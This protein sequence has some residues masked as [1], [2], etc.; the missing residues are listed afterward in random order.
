MSTSSDH[1]RKANPLHPL[2]Q[3]I[4]IPQHQYSDIIFAF[5]ADCAKYLTTEDTYLSN[6][7]TIWQI[8]DGEIE[9]SIAGELRHGYAQHILIFAPQDKIRV[10]SFTN[11]L[12]LA[13]LCIPQLLMNSAMRTETYKEKLLILPFILKQRDGIDM[14]HA[15]LNE[16]TRNEIDYLFGMIIDRVPPAASL[17]SV[18]I[19]I[20]L[21]EALILMVIENLGVP[22]N[23]I[24]PESHMEKM[25][26]DFMVSLQGNYI[27]HQDVAFYAAQACVSVKYFTAVIK[28]LT[29]ATPVEWISRMLTTRAREL[30]WLTDR[31]VNDISDELRFSSPS[32]FIRFFHRRTGF[33]PKQYKSLQ[34][35]TH[36]RPKKSD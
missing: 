14:H 3:M 26:T 10:H 8:Q 21:I 7:W 30:L 27:E 23:A 35:K 9:Y 24:R 16:K 31:T 25:A 1:I 11:K 18:E 15:E 4:F 19:V 29:S 2:L 20:P 22:H 33:T 36:T 28:S 13:V 34:Q 6:G 5:R 17:S 32:V 12:Q